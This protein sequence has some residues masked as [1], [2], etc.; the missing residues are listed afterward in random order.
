MTK[1]G[2]VDEAAGK[3]RTEIERGIDPDKLKAE[4]KSREVRLGLVLYGGVSLAIYINGVAH[5]FFR[6]V[7]GRG[8]YRLIKALTDSDIVVDIISGTSAGGVNGIFLAYALCNGCEFGETARV[9]RNHGGIRNLLRDPRP[10]TDT[11][12]LL[13]SEGYYQPHLEDAFRTMFQGSSSELEDAS[14]VQELDLFVTGTDLKGRVYT[15]FDDAGHPIDVKNH[16]AVFQLK[17]RRGRKRPFR[18]GDGEDRDTTDRALA[19][20]SRLT[21]TFPV[22]FSP[23]H[24]PERADA[25]VDAKLREWGQLDR[26]DTWFIDGGVLDNK[27]FSYTIRE[28][29]FRAADREVDR[30]LFYV[31]PD[32]E[33]F[34][35]A[36]HRLSEEGPTGQPPPNIV[37]VAL[38]ALIGIPGYESIAEDLKMLAERNSRLQ[39][40]HRLVDQ[41]QSAISQSSKA[42]QAEASDLT[43]ILYRRASLIALSERVIEGLFKTGD[44]RDLIIEPDNR[45]RAAALVRR[46][47]ELILGDTQSAAADELLRQ[48]DVYYS[49]R[50][51]FRVTYLLYDLLFG[52]TP[53]SYRGLD[54]SDRLSRYRVLLRHLNRQM[55]LYEVVLAAMESLLDDVPFD[56]RKGQGRAAFD[57]LWLQVQNAMARL[58]ADN[59][60]AAHLLPK[61][62]GRDLD[63]L[64]SGQLGKV[65]DSL[66]ECI[67]TIAAEV[68]DRTFQLSEEMPQ[69]LLPKLGGYESA[70]LDLLPPD[71]PVRAAYKDFALLDAQLYPI[72]LVAGMRE[73]DIIEIVRISPA[74]ADKGFSRRGFSDKV[75]GDVLYHFGAFFKRSWRSNDILWGRIDGCCQLV[76][77][78]FDRE[79]IRKVMSSQE[80][81]Q[82]IRASDSLRTVKLFPHAGTGAQES[83]DRWVQCIAS[84]DDSEREEALANT[85]NLE[86]LIEAAQ[87][88]I[89]AQDIT[90]VMEDALIEQA[91]WNRYEVAVQAAS[92]H[93]AGAVG[94]PPWI[95][96]PGKTF[97][98]NFVADAAAARV[99]VD[100]MARLSATSDALRPADTTLGKFFRDTYKVGAEQLTRDIPTYALL[101]I[102]AIGLLVLR[103][104]LLGVLGPQAD[105]V[106]R[107]WLNR[108]VLSPML[109]SFYALT[110]ASRSRP[111]PLARTLVYVWIGG[112]IVF[113]ILLLA[114]YTILGVI[115]GT[116]LL[117]AVVLAGYE[118]ARAGRRRL[119]GGL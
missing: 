18:P 1:F 57:A 28:I 65:N 13:N 77:V 19:T 32:P 75:A 37:Q 97:I 72:E 82:A 101:E 35:D 6:A 3:P 38:A 64:P 33:R 12:S 98:D 48:F 113:L 91:D 59:S 114:G 80:R 31:E 109:W 61:S 34:A 106:K 29:F 10:E 90:N 84:E 40:Y 44:R 15:Q 112:L 67:Q 56:W 107:H 116:G 78:L 103:N 54:L 5:E 79:R 53:P 85:A 4:A 23:L 69:T 9:W 22:A 42:T 89:V 115:L 45:E 39:Q 88:E 92:T 55:K 93:A 26:A 76:E 108:W 94:L 2:A 7:R 99:L 21:S 74:D 43:A 100:E 17:H 102:F 87:L 47:D 63:W 24:L 68:R 96:Q 118:L 71:D 27:P 25:V 50:R 46:F 70:M 81:R 49:L 117:L 104:C 58:L 41:M 11:N 119:E 16:R 62:Y 20:L 66:R 86:L 60:A 105:R 83:L 73:K 95:F 51:L 14:E 111:T 8:V 30:K 36:R 110:S 52:E